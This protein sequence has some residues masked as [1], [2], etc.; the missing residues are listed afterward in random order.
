MTGASRD[1]AAGHGYS[2]RTGR[3]RAGVRRRR[4]VPAGAAGRAGDAGLRSM[5]VTPGPVRSRPPENPVMASGERGTAGLR[6]GRPAAPLCPRDLLAADVPER[7]VTAGSRDPSALRAIPQCS[8]WT[9]PAVPGGHR[10]IVTRGRAPGPASAF[11]LA[12]RKV[13]VIR[14]SRSE[15]ES[16]ISAWTRN[17]SSAPPCFMTRP[18]ITPVTWP[19]ADNT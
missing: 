16:R 17:L 14:S 3:F 2:R 11:P 19:R 7:R 6:P 1:A 4:T 8:S 13:P 10:R 5:P 15:Q 18:G 12:A 9:V